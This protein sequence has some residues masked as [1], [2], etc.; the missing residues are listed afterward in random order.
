M[1]DETR[2]LFEYYKTLNDQERGLYTT[3]LVVSLVKDVTY[4]I[5][6]G[7]VVWSLGRRLIGAITAAIRESK[8]ERA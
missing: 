5:V 1:I 3:W 4:Y 6:V 8:R 7:L 2:A